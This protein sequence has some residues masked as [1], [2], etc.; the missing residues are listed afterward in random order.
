MAYKVN[1]FTGELTRVL[2]SD[3][4]VGG[5][6]LDELQEQANENTTNI[7]VNAAAITLLQQQSQT[8]VTKTSDY[9]ATNTDYTILADAT[10]NTVT[11][12][13]PNATEAMP[14]LPTER[15]VYQIKC[16][17][18]T[19]ACKVSGNGNAIDGSTDDFQIYKDE[20]LTVIYDSTNG[21]SIL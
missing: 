15:G 14:E 11:I 19:Y 2:D 20:S 9:T 12:S 5:I 10:S 21:W 6:D 7:S 18:D 17:N 8:V 1:P 4:A 13:L 16:L 3:E